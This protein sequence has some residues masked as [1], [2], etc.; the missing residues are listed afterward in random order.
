MKILERLSYKLNLTQTELKIFLFLFSAL[1]LGIIINIW[2]TN[3]KSDYLEFDYSDQDSLFYNSFEE[4]VEKDTTLNKSKMDS[5][6][7]FE[8]KKVKIVST[9]KDKTNKIIKINFASVE[10]ISQLPGIGIKTANN[11]IEYRNKKGKINTA[12]ELLNVKGIG[13]TKLEKIR[14]LLNFDK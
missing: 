12:D 2:K 14:M 10:E 3:Q 1:V 11:I 8:L 13:K 5:T 6:K 9:K 7:S 4:I